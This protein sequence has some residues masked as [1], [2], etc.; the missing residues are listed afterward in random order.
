MAKTSLFKWITLSDFML[1]LMASTM[2]GRLNPCS[3]GLPS[4]TY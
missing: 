3:N 2:P 4:L 1:V